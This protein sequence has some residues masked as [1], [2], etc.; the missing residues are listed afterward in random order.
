VK[1]IF[2]AVILV[3][4]LSGGA[5]VNADQPITVSVYPAIAVARG[6][7]QLKIF[8]QR[9]DENRTL[10]WEVDGP[11]FYRSSTAQL[12]G[13]AAPRSWFFFIKDLPEGTFDVRATVK[14]SNNSES[15]ALASI[16]VISGMR[17]EDR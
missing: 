8:V 15:F 10:N 2:V 12:E 17:N 7:A 14:R 1:R 9:N 13:S 3:G 5:S 11:G 4:A 16:T 6:T